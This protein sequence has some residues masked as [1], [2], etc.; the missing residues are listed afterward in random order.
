MNVGCIIGAAVWNAESG[1]DTRETMRLANEAL[2]I[3]KRTGKN[4]I[5][6]EANS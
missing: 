5:A 3:S 6:F 2:Y 1:Q 4:R